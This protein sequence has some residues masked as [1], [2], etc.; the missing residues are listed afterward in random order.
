MV[1]NDLKVK[2]INKSHPD[3]KRLSLCAENM[4]VDIKKSYEINKKL[5]EVI[6]EFCGSQDQ[7]AK[8][9]CISIY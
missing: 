1:L 2:K 6:S 5:L 9:S 8:I 7:N 4:V 3:R